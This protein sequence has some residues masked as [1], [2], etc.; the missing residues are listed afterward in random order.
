MAVAPSIQESILTSF[1]PKP[2]P[3]TPIFRTY[4]KYHEEVEKKGKKSSLYAMGAASLE[5][6]TTRGLLLAHPKALA[7]CQVQVPSFRGGWS[8]PGDG[9][10]TLVAVISISTSRLSF[11][12]SLM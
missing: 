6:I 2:I 5:F 9:D 7:L 1:F 8:H 4:L 10:V 12:P 11:L 3:H